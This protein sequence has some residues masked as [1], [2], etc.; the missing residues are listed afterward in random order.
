MDVYFFCLMIRRTPLSK[1]TDTLLPDTTHFRSDHDR[2][3]WRQRTIRPAGDALQTDARAIFAVSGVERLV[4]CGGETAD[5][6]RIRVGSPVVAQYTVD[7]QRIDPRGRPDR[8]EARSV[9][10]AGGIPPWRNLSVGYPRKYG[11]GHQKRPYEE[12]PVG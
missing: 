11:T 9:K 12:R 2:R 6:R 3:K 1:R 10:G 5:S 4:R 8:Q 7:D